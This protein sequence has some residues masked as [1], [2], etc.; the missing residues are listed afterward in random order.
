SQPP[1]GSAGWGRLSCG[2]RSGKTTTTVSE[3]NTV[4]RDDSSVTGMPDA[5]TGFRMKMSRANHS[6]RD[7][8][9]TP[10]Y[11]IRPNRNTARIATAV[12]A[13]NV[14]AGFTGRLIAN[15]PVTAITTTPAPT[16]GNV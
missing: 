1:E 2:D 14:T 8:S 12:P 16:C 11:G 9:R 13:K 10:V 7:V 3:T 6:A 5:D 4:F 15:V